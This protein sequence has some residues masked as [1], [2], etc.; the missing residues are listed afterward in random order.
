[1]AFFKFCW[2]DI[3]PTSD[4]DE[5][6][7]AYERAG[8]PVLYTSAPSKRGIPELGEALRD[9]ITALVGPSGAGKSTL[10]N[11]IE[12]GLGL[13]VGAVS[14][15]LGLGRHI[16]VEATLH[17]LKIGGY[18]ADTPGL[19]KLK[20]WEIPEG[21]LDWAFRDFRS[22]LGSC[23]FPDCRHLQEPECGVRAAVE[24][25]EIP[26]QRHRSYR[27]ILAEREEARPY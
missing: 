16:T 24:R 3:L 26:E 22:Y 21:A 1:M 19:R 2:I 9:R 10:L 5:I 17:P 12:P 14:R 20:L 23:R 15:S 25:G 7:S 6:F 27:A 4:P 11:T 13:R 18:V 8:Y